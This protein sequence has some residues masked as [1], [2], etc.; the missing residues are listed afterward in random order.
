M[1]KGKKS[2][3]ALHFLALLKTQVASMT[4][5]LEDNSEDMDEKSDGDEA[6]SDNEISD[7]DNFTD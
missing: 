5:G 7:E 1:L 6:N 4:V 2:K 3:T